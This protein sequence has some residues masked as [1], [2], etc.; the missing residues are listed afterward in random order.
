MLYFGHDYLLKFF[1]RDWC[2]NL[3]T[4][5]WSSK[6]N[7]LLTFISRKMACESSLDARLTSHFDC[8]VDMLEQNSK[9]LSV[10]VSLWKFFF[11]ALIKI[12]NRLSNKPR[13]KKYKYKS[14]LRCTSC[15]NIC[16]N[17]RFYCTT[18]INTINP[19]KCVAQAVKS[20][21]EWS[22]CRFSEIFR[23]PGN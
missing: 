23:P 18:T 14:S 5:E 20:N 4:V 17:S 19:R 15:G 9:S 3:N 22:K 2:W 7:W 8:D 1:D 16:G 21:W 13:M 12:R 10:Q 11:S 6:D